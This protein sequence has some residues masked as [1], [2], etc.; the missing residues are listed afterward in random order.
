[1]KA[2]VTLLSF[3]LISSA[4]LF[5]QSNEGKSRKEMIQA[6]KVGFITS[7]VRLT[8]EEAKTFWPIY[9]DR[10]TE[11][12]EVR[13][14]RRQ[15][16]RK[17]RDSLEEISD[18]EL[19]TMLDGEFEGKQK[20]LDIKKK[21]HVR[22]KE[23]IGIKKT[24]KLYRAEHRFDAKLVRGSRAKAQQLRHETGSPSPSNAR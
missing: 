17:F 16:R 7:Q 8:T 5:A 21:Y 13:K 18:A 4:T 20:E 9:D 6:Q 12:Q 23:S 11:L 24:A 10:E 19:E 1:M 15:L 22:F 2:L 3:L 14:R